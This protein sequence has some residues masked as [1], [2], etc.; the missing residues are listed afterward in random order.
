[1]TCAIVA[2][3]CLFIPSSFAQVRNTEPSAGFTKT[4][5]D[6]KERYAKVPAFS[7][8]YKMI[9]K[10]FKGPPTVYTGHLIFQK[11]L[12]VHVE[13][14]R[15][16]P[17]PNLKVGHGLIIDDGLYEWHRT[18]PLDTMMAPPTNPKGAAFLNEQSKVVTVTKAKLRTALAGIGMMF[19]ATPPKENFPPGMRMVMLAA[20]SGLK[21]HAFDPYTALDERFIMEGKGTPELFTVIENKHESF[22]RKAIYLGRQ[23]GV[24]RKLQVFDYRSGTDVEQELV[25]TNLN[26][27]PAIDEGTFKFVP[28]KGEK[29]L[30]VDAAFKQPPG[31]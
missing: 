1:M 18:P 3:L 11:D 16:A 17:F 19:G 15:Q 8:D 7:A 23:D 27:K 14:T 12:K 4:L 9:E 30:D 25:L 13:Y 26:L 22:A 29:I 20:R 5:F 21:P 31:R 6:L 10:S 24:L 28:A 2:L